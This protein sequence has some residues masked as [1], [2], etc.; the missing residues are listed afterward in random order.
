MVSVANVEPARLQSIIAELA[1]AGAPERSAA[2]AIRNGRRRVVLSG[3]PA[4][5]ARVQEKCEQIAAEE[6]R[7]RDA[8]KRGGAVFAPVFGN[9]GDPVHHA[10]GRRQR[11]AAVRHSPS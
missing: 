8:K 9:V 2:L 6:E 7:D 4:Q 1:I 11:T 5:L 3:P 10:Q